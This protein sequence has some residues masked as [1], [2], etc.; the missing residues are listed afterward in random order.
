MDVRASVA[1]GDG[2]AT[3][4]RSS[5][6]AEL[7]AVLERLRAF[8]AEGDVEAARCL[9]EELKCRWPDSQTVRY[10]ARVLAPPVVT[11]EPG[12]RGRSLDRERAWLREHADEYPGCWLAIYGDR[13]VAADRDLAVVLQ[14]VRETP[15][16]ETALLY[17]HPSPSE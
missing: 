7:D 4:R 15:G 11:V 9:V 3:A 6:E 16:A 10:W 14:G 2:T 17:Y 8:L 12:E 5:E 13:L 1:S